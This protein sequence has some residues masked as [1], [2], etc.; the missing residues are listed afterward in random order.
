MIEYINLINLL[1]SSLNKPECIFSFLWKNVRFS[2]QICQVFINSYF[3][4]LFV[5]FLPFTIKSTVTSSKSSP[6]AN[7][8]SDYSYPIPATKQPSRALSFTKPS[9]SHLCC[10]LPRSSFTPYPCRPEKSPKQRDASAKASFHCG[11]R[12]FPAILVSLR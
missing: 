2:E 3:T 5:E 1:L 11:H 4:Y 7:V 12:V 6:R 8:L 9:R 10:S